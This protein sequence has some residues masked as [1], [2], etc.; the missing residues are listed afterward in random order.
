MCVL[1][2]AISLT[3]VLIY[4]IPLTCVFLVVSLSVDERNECLENLSLEAHRLCIKN[5]VSSFFLLQPTT[6]QKG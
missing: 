3:C 6:I 1:I 5:A 4:A 2:Y